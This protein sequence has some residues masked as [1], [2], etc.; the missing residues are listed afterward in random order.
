[1]IGYEIEIRGL[2]E[3][4]AK[5]GRFDEISD[6][7]LSTAMSK[8]VIGIES[9]ARQHWPVGVTGRSRNSIASQVVR[10]GPGSIV[11]K[12]GST[13]VGEVYPA[14]VEFG[15]KPGKAPPPGA[16]DRWVH[17]VLGI[18]ND[19]APGVAYLVGR[20]IA[21]R[22]IKGRFVFKKAWAKMK[23]VVERNFA[24][25]LDEITEDLSLGNG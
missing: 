6:R 4:V 23:P 2:E 14:V 5:L 24:V 7:R 3:Q 8:L 21:R 19:E 10:E 15:R 1:M 17:I 16:L 9:E 25:A 22:G 12:V 18:S 13:L 20:A 11:G